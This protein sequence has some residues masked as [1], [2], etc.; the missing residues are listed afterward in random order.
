MS[1]HVWA[2]SVGGSRPPL[3]GF[4]VTVHDSGPRRLDAI[5]G[6]RRLGTPVEGEDVPE[7]EREPGQPCRRNQ[8]TLPSVVGSAPHSS[9]M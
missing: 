9:L 6:R 8:V 3:G 2:P 7:R 1:D 5:A 4:G